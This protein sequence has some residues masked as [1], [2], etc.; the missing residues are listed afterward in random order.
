MAWRRAF[1]RALGCGAGDEAGKSGV[2]QPGGPLR[3]ASADGNRRAA[4]HD[5]AACGNVHL[6][7]ARPSHCLALA[8]QDGRRR[9]Q[10]SEEHT[11]ELQSLMRTSYAVFCLKKKKL[12]RLTSLAEVD[13]NITHL[14]ATHLS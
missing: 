11:S 1:G 6:Q 3:E 9:G 5:P 14:Y 8:D 7:P 2:G 4:H 10:R 12:V 13:L